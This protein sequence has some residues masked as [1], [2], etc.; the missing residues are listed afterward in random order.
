V[1]CHREKNLGG[2]VMRNDPGRDSLDAWK[3]TG[4]A[5]GCLR[6]AASI[7]GDD[8]GFLWRDPDFCGGGSADFA[9]IARIIFEYC[10]PKPLINL[11]KF[12]NLFMQFLLHARAA[13][14]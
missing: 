4:R 6:R 12:H 13:R 2:G 9:Q 5:G 3:P 10:Q 14:L 1:D 8:H 7:A 11:T